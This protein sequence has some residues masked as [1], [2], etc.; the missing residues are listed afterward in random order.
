MLDHP[1]AEFLAHV[2]RPGRYVGGEFGA[3]VFARREDFWGKRI[4]I[5]GDSLTGPEYGQAVGAA[6]G[7]EIGYFEVPRDQVRQMSEDMALMYEWF[8]RVGYSADIEG[9]RRNYPEVK[10]ERFSEWAARQDWSI[11][12]AAAKTAN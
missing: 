7:R 1:Y 3:L 9:L 10:W 6:S 8:E 12:E 11:L 5:A 4:N 2:E